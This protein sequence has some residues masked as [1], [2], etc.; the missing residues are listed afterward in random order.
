VISLVCQVKH[1]LVMLWVPPV[2]RRWKAHKVN[3]RGIS[4]VARGLFPEKGDRIEGI[5]VH[6]SSRLVSD[7]QKSGRNGLRILRVDIKL[8]IDLHDP[9]AFGTCERIDL[10]GSSPGQAAIFW[11]RRAQ[12]FLNSSDEPFGSRIEG[13]KRS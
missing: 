11:M 5:W 7:L 9:R 3:Q 12:L 2:R 6:G 8:L 13:I 4:K 1:D 10:P